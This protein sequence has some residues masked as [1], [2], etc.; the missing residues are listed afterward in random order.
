MTAANQTVTRVLMMT[1]TCHNPQSKVMNSQSMSVVCQLT[2]LSQL[3]SMSTGHAA[4][5]IEVK[6]GVE[7]MVEDLHIAHIHL[8]NRYIRFIV[9]WKNIFAWKLEPPPVG[10]RRQQDIIRTQ[11]SVTA[12]SDATYVINVFQ[13][14]FTRETVDNIVP[15]TNH[16]DNWLIRN[17]NEEHPNAMCEPGM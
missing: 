13:S 3:Q 2:A 10:F 12:V 4:R 1:T 15:Q 6:A 11:A 8:W 17:W 5:H 14:I 9:I 16:K 7:L